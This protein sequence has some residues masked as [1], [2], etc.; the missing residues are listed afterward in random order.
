MT[1]GLKVL[2]SILS[3]TVAT[4]GAVSHFT[5]FWKVGGYL[6]LILECYSRGNPCGLYA[7]KHELTLPPVSFP[8]HHYNHRRVRYIVLPVD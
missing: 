5:G 1:D 6:R 2:I 3:N 4:I 7:S 8:I